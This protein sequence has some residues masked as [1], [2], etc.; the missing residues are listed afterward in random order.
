MCIEY[1]AEFEEKK[2]Q[3]ACQDGYARRLEAAR[4]AVRRLKEIAESQ[5]DSD[6]AEDYSDRESQYL[7]QRHSITRKKRW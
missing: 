5:G 1:A 4:L 6:H 2:A 3:Y 7:G